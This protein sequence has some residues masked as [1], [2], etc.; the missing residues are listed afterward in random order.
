MKLLEMR[1]AAYG[2]FTDLAVDLSAG[3]EG[4]HVIYGPNEAGKSS[5]LRALRHLFY[6][7]PVQSADDFIHPY[8]KMRIGAT[9]EAGSGERLEFLRRKGRSNTLRASDDQTLIEDSRLYQFLSGVDAEHFATM[10]GIGY[11]DLVRGGREIVQGGGNLGQLIFAA[12]SG[13]ANLREIQNELQ[14]EAAALF[15]PAGQ[16]PRINATLG[17]INKYRK[18]MREAQLPGREWENH[19]Q[20][21]RRAE[22]RIEVVESEL[23]QRQREWHRLERIQDALPLIGKRQALLGELKEYAAAVILPD[24]FAEQRRDLLTRIGV[25]KSERD[26]SLQ[27][28]AAVEKAVAELEVSNRILESSERIEEVYQELGTQRKAAKDRIKLDTRKAGLRSEAKDILR[29]LREDLTVDDAGQLRIKKTDAVHIQELG[30]AYERITTRLETSREAIPGLKRRIRGL[31]EKLQKLG[32]P[33]P[34]E[35]LVSAVEQAEA[36]VADEKHCRAALSDIRAARQ[37]LEIKLNK[38]SLWTGSLEKLEHLAVPPS[39]TINLFEKRHSEAGIECQ[40]IQEAHDKLTRTL[41]DLARRIEALQLQ[42]QVPTEE[43]LHQMRAIRDR[44]W[45]LVA[46][47][48][49]GEAPSE[50]QIAE[51]I[52]ELPPSATLTEAYQ[53]SLGQSDEIADRLR[54]EAEQVAVKAKLLADQSALEKQLDQLNAEQDRALIALKDL[55]TEWIELWQPLGITPQTPKE[56]QLWLQNFNTMADK[57]TELREK[58][59]KVNAMQAEIAAHVEKLDR[60]L[61]NMGD[62]PSQGEKS[63]DHLVKKARKIIADEDKHRR[64]QEQLASETSQRGGELADARLKVE[65]SEKELARWQKDWE[66]A[67]RPLGLEADAIPPQASAVMTELKDLFDKLKEADILQKRIEGIDRDQVQ[68]AAK[69]LDLADTAAGD[70][71]EL[72]PQAAAA[73]LNTRLTRARRAESQRQT[74][75]DQRQREKKRLD[76]SIQAIAG[77]ET[78]LDGM[79]REAGCSTYDELPGAEKRSAKR[80]RLEADLSR[81]DERLLE[82]SGG[83][84]TDNFI[85]DALKVDPDSI[86]GDIELLRENIEKLNQEKSE[87][88][89]TIGEERTE[90]RRMDGSAGAA[91]A[92]EDIQIQVG[93]LENDIE[94]YARLKIASRVMNLAI[95]RFRDKSQG[96]I[97]SRASSLFRQITGRS[98]DGVRAEFDGDGNPMLV[99]VRAGS[100]EIVAV[101]GMSDGTADQLYLALRLAGLEEY[102]AANEPMPFIVDDI[103]IK[104]DDARATATLQALAEL[105]AKTQVIFFTHHRHLVRL[106]ED[107]VAEGILIRHDLV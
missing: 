97:L 37:T 92:A 56:M 54:R 79:C 18:Q 27:N 53:S 51:Y 61:A 90:L 84:T 48:L 38:Q 82:L 24:D 102:L 96:P 91:E 64:N 70:L 6:G 17:L 26:Q 76:K 94:Q 2:P 52:A 30:S 8:A 71:K 5:A 103:L 32:A 98:F 40:R 15:R 86:V 68:F 41:A 72:P 74:L 57:A 100:G 3:N 12:G 20:A 36:Y 69:V 66:K 67:V 65:T 11:P 14:S 60:H 105:S 78:R 101:E 43:D 80:L 42:Q 89:Q 16:R 99:G 93:R 87:L 44:G 35:D 13:V 95:E 1:L 28:I 73:E 83:A 59:T 25:S 39:E 22:D 50:A 77:T 106:A 4:L 9:I 34:I 31:D 7:I 46:D 55:D 23:R 62:S 85:R 10:F 107:N 45:Q 49:A 81:L 47:T 19:Y 104:F 58:Q 63:L 88:N 33:R 29:G 75:Q 21:L